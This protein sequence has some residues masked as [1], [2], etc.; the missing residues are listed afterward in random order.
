[1]IKKLSI[2]TAAA[3]IS[4]WMLAVP[5]PAFAAGQVPF[6]GSDAGHFDVPGSCEGDGLQVVIEG[7]GH[8]THLGRYAYAANECFHPS[9]AAFTGTP[10]FTAPNGDTMLGH[11]RGQVFPT[12]DPDVIT[13]EEDLAITGGTGRF[14]G[15]NEQLHVNGVANLAT[16]EYNQTLSGNVSK[17]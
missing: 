12:D 2:A 14:A 13:Y 7:A 6:K 5:A 4:G 8:A 9:T 17:P 3:L 15:V 11:Y 16:G 1:M 10:T